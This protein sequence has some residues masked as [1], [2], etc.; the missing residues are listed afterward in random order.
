MEMKK[1]LLRMEKEEVVELPSAGREEFLVFHVKHE[2]E[3]FL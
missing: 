2:V 3:T 1:W